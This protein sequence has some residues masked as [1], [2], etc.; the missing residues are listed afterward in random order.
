MEQ[1]VEAGGPDETVLAIVHG[2]V[3]AEVC[4][5]V[6]GSRAFAFLYADNGSITR[7]MRL[8]SRRWALISFNETSHLGEDG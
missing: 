3:I 1:L 2:G 7:I 4:R 6:T 8:P 5:Q